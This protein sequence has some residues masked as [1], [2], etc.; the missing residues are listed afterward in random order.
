[1]QLDDLAKGRHYVPRL[2]GVGQIVEGTMASP[3]TLDPLKRNAR[4][5]G[6]WTRE[7]I[8]FLL[9]VPEK[10][11]AGEKVPVVMFG[12]GM[13]T[14]RRF[15]L[16][17]AGVLAQRGFAALAIDLPFHGER[18]Q[19]SRIPMLI[20]NFYPGPVRIR[21]L[22][23][24]N[25]LLFFPACAEGS[26]CSAEGRC[27]TE[28]GAM[29]AFTRVPLS[30]LPVASGTTMFEFDPP[31]FVD[32]VEQ[33][34][35]DMV[36][37]RRSL[38]LADWSKVTGGVALESER[39][40][41]AGQSLGA[42]VGAAFVSVTS[43]VERAVF[44]SPQADLLGM[45]R[46]STLFGPITRAV[47]DHLKLA[48][49]S[50]ERELILSAARWIFDAIDPQSLAPGLAGRSAFIQMN[51]ADLVVPNPGT[52]RFQRATKLPMKTYPAALHGALVIP[53]P[54]DAMLTDLVESLAGGQIE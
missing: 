42:M 51:K 48:D 18:T 54:G 2:R 40:L 37:V 10:A 19:C 50:F 20:P 43:D 28:H 13:L 25:D 47:L 52:E 32:R 8:P 30:D 16:T 7:D 23:L 36:T 1:S 21:E 22:T 14:D 24:G 41:F 33:A 11:A 45:Y 34:I 26:T 29:S 9:T 17:I 44:N 5:D 12:H 38:R 39:V 6:S 31:A 3:G 53:G 15:L 4:A 27:V 46:E 35:I 49:G